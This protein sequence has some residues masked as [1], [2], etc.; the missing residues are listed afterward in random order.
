M[1]I[2]NLN[3]SW[4]WLTTQWLD[5]L[6]IS[7]LSGITHV[8]TFI[9]LWGANG[10]S[11]LAGV[12]EVGFCFSSPSS[13]TPSLSIWSPR[14]RA[15]APDPGTL[16]G[17][18]CMCCS[19]S[20]GLTFGWCCPSPAS[21]SLPSW[22]PS[23]SPCWCQ[24]DG[25]GGNPGTLGLPGCQWWGA[26]VWC[27]GDDRSVISVLS[28]SRYRSWLYG[29][30]AAAETSAMMTTTPATPVS[31]SR[32]PL[33]ATLLLCLSTTS[34]GGLAIEP[35]HSCVVLSG[36]W[37]CYTLL[38]MSWWLRWCLGASLLCLQSL[39]LKSFT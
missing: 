12:G 24:R 9:G 18:R 29:G 6:A 14:S 36:A 3:F 23:P 39:R 4:A 38:F 34:N 25:R 15:H 31:S 33:W 28:W 30:A 32:Q 37:Y 20:T 22:R 10:K 35:W 27:P 8:H 16:A 13:T 7:I 5:N 17:S 1:E 19:A 21:P 2:Y 26:V 11:L